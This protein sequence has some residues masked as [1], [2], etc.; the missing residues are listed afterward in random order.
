MSCTSSLKNDLLCIGRGWGVSKSSNV[1]LCWMLVWWFHYKFLFAPQFRHLHP[2]SHIAYSTEDHWS[3]L[4]I[5][6]Q[7]PHCTPIL[8]FAPPFWHLTP[9][10][11]KRLFWRSKIKKKSPKFFCGSGIHIRNTFCKKNGPKRPFQPSAVVR[12]I[13]RSLYGVATTN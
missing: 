13:Y 4:M 2:H 1:L 7:F 5:L 3:L 11:K 12:A 6:L 8:T 9:S 10:W